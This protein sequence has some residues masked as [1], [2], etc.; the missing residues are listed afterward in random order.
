[1]IVVTGSARTG[2]SLM[3]RIL[4]ELGFPTP[5][6]KFNEAMKGLEKY[7]PDGFWEIGDLSKHGVQSDKYK[8]QA[9]K[10]FGYGLSITPKE[11]VN[12]VIVCKRDRDA[13]VESSK[14]VFEQLYANLGQPNPA[15]GV[16]DQFYD[17]HYAYI[18]DYIIDVDSLLIHL[19]DMKVDPGSQ[20]A[21]IAG[22]LRI[23]IKE[24]TRTRIINSIHRTP[25]AE[26]HK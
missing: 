13:A 1:M 10:V 7:N 15:K 11:Y 26:A 12:K 22:F 2:T 16:E 14:E 17:S 3:V 18:D 23:T 20:L 19:E 24:V 25:L 6:P 8:G 9:V 4:T 21:R 5:A